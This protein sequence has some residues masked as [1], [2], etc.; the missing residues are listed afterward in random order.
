MITNR[1]EWAALKGKIAFDI[2]I[3]SKKRDIAIWMNNL[4]NNRASK[5]KFSSRYKVEKEYAK[6]R[7]QYMHKGSDGHWYRNEGM[8]KKEGEGRD[9]YWTPIKQV[10]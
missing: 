2:T 3:N 5:N 7:N 6:F 9:A 8:W 4:P 10:K 1:S